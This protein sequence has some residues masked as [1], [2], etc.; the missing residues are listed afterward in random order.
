MEI[1]AKG[2]E[3]YGIYNIVETFVEN[4]ESK[5]LTQLLSVFEIQKKD[6]AAIYA[7]ATFAANKTWRLEQKGARETISSEAYYSILLN[8]SKKFV[9]PKTRIVFTFAGIRYSLE[10]NA[11]RNYSVVQVDYHGDS[12]VHHEHLLKDFLSIDVL[13]ELYMSLEE[14]FARLHLEQKP[15]GSLHDVV[16]I[17]KSAV[18][19]QNKKAGI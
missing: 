13:G 16:S 3:L 6:E 7:K 17:F 2:A 4:E 10:S 18:T 8:T 14:T 9:E 12:N 5:T 19:D 15:A 1:K 11:E